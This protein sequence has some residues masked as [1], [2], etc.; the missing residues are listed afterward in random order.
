VSFEEF[1]AARL[2][3]LLRYAV[4]LTG[5]RDLAEDLVQDVLVTAHRRWK[6]IAATD[7]PDQYVYRMVTNAYLSWRRRWSTRHIV[8][9]EP[10]DRPAA[11]AGP[12][13]RPQHSELWLR[14]ARLPRQQ[15]AAIVLRY[16]EGLSVA[17]TADVL[18]CAP[19]TVRSN[20]SRALAALRVAAPQL[21]YD[22]GE[23]G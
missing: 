12:E 20:T 7:R 19:A 13:D 6:R 3:A 23:H 17:E 18:G 8:L 4:V 15:R 16:Y 11:G 2:P 9:L 5:D 22:Q 14:L 1:V 21:A 10:P